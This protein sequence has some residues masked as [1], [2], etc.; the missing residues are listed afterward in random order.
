MWDY[1]ARN[2]KTGKIL[3]YFRRDLWES[4]VRNNAHIVK[5]SRK[6]A[7]DFKVDGAVNRTYNDNSPI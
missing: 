1:Y 2:T 7:K 6:D 5:I 4:D 3:R